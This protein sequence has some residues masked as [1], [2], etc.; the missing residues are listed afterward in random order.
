MKT[1]KMIFLFVPILIYAFF[2]LAVESIGKKI[3]G[4]RYKRSVEKNEKERR[5]YIH[6]ITPRTRV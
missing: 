5:K 6:W 4:Y 3:D 1:I 2:K